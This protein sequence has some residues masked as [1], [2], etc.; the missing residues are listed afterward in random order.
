VENS[1]LN[2][3]KMSSAQPITQT[4]TRKRLLTRERN[5]S[6]DVRLLN[7]HNFY[8]SLEEQKAQI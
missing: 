4:Q 2:S 3:K 8:R 6:V 7:I 5:D 1:I